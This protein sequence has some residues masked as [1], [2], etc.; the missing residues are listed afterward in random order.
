MEGKGTVYDPAVAEDGD[1]SLAILLIRY[2]IDQ[3]YHKKRNRKSI[4]TLP[5]RMG[6]GV[7]A[8]PVFLK[9]E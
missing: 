1:V 9:E 6:S 2:I 8:F 5:P 7:Y 3:I 4:P